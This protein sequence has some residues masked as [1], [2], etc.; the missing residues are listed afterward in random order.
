MRRLRDQSGDLEALGIHRSGNEINFG[1]RWNAPDLV[2]LPM[3]LHDD[4]PMEALQGR[5]RARWRK[6]SSSGSILASSGICLAI[7]MA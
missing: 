1:G 2:A 6:R 5:T 3:E 7:C 4:L